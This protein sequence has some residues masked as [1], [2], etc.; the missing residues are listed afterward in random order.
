MDVTDSKHSALPSSI[1]ADSHTHKHEYPPIGE[2]TVVPTLTSIPTNTHTDPNPK[3]STS[4]HD[5]ENAQ[6][7]SPQDITGFRERIRAYPRPFAILAG[8]IFLL[9]VSLVGLVLYMVLVPNAFDGGM[10]IVNA[11]FVV[12]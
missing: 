1:H 6:P 3:A 4:T 9:V 11:L 5:V 8:L 7:K 10:A 12:L 2:I